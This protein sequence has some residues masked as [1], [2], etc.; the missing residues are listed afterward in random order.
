MLM[1]N[2][3]EDCF[4]IAS[5]LA[6][7][8]GGQVHFLKPL[9]RYGTGQLPNDPSKYGAYAYHAFVLKGSKY[10]DEFFENG[11][12]FADWLS[13]YKQLNNFSDEMMELLMKIDSIAPPGVWK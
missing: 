8:I 13:Q 12:E 2:S 11:I 10:F 1:H 3:G 9:G 7:R 4:V 5:R 6:E